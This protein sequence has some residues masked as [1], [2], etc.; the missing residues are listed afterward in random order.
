MAV[1]SP[2]SKYS[3]QECMLAEYSPRRIGA[4][5]GMGTPLAPP[6]S[7]LLS[8]ERRWGVPQETPADR[9]RVFRRE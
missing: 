2:R 3:A 1:N 7:H 8:A 4:P 9:G 6:P 5:E